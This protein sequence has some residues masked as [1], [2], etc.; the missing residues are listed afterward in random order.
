MSNLHNITL[1]NIHYCSYSSQPCVDIYC[2]GTT[3]YVDIVD[4]GIPNV[5]MANGNEIDH[6]PV[7]YSFD[8]VNVSCE[9]CLVKKD[10]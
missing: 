4:T 9:D 10:S 6:A 5:Y 2:T 1:Y 3:H 7:Y 8:W